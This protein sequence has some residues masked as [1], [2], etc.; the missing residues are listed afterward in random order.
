MGLLV[1]YSLKEGQAEAQVEA[2]N[3]FVAGLN[4][5]G[6]QGYSYTA[7]ETND[8][9]KFIAVLEFDD[10]AAKQRFLDSAAFAEYRDGAGARFVG[11]PQTTVIRRVASTLD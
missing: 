5:T 1:E 4:S 8:P 9:T 11:P 10:A 6:D 7:Y 2:L 3:T